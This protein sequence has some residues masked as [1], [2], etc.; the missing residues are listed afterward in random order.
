MVSKLRANNLHW[1]LQ[2]YQNNI[3]LQG[4]K[5]FFSSWEQTFMR[6]KFPVTINRQNSLLKQIDLLTDIRRL[7]KFQGMRTIFPYFIE[8]S[9]GFSIGYLSVKW[10]LEGSC[11]YIRV[12]SSYKRAKWAWNWSWPIF[13]IRV[14]VLDD[15]THPVYIVKFCRKNS[16]R[17]SKI[18]KFEK[19]AI[20]ES[21]ILLTGIWSSTM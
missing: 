8:F 4:V 18:W 14:I 20:F 9:I 21:K 2:V 1:G 13:E 10:Y 19:K 6:C 3:V 12:L 11:T 15:D 17:L 16:K 5:M 7:T